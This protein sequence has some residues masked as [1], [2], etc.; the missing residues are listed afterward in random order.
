MKNWLRWKWKLRVVG[1]KSLTK[2]NDDDDDK[3]ENR[4]EKLSKIDLIMLSTFLN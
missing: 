1:M 4:G 3:D 2:N